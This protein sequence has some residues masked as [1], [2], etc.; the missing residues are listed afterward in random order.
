MIGSMISEK[1][2]VINYAIQTRRI[3]DILERSD[4]AGRE[5]DVHEKPL[6]KEAKD[7][8]ENLLAGAYYIYRRGDREQLGPTFL[9]LRDLRIS[10]SIFDRL[11]WTPGGDSI[12]NNLISV[13]NHLDAIVT[14]GALS[15]ERDE[16]LVFLR[17]FFEELSA[18]MHE[19]MLANKLSP[20]ENYSSQLWHKMT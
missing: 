7:L 18:R 6:F 14:S 5:L 3:A 10:H 12:V 19:A 17:E 16:D 11:Q 4:L 8:V 13:R 2:A 15:F 9:G 20:V 1:N